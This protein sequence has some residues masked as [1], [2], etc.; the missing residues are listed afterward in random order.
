MR[1]EREKSEERETSE[2]REIRREM[3]GEERERELKRDEKKERSEEGEPVIVVFFEPI[4]GIGPI[5]KIVSLI[6]L[7]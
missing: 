7:T 2:M 6:C 1:A 4:F 3:R 5:C